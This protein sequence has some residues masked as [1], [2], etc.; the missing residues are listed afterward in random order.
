MSRK[1]K[2][3]S[4][5]RDARFLWGVRSY[6]AM[7]PDASGWALQPC[8]SRETAERVYEQLSA[9]DNS[10]IISYTLVPVPRQLADK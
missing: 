3:K 5:A 8:N 9:H 7:D 6:D 2:K 10:G 4:A 1:S